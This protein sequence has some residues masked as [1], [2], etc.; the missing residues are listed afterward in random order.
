MLEL[1][2]QWLALDALD[3]SRLVVVSRGAVAARPGDPLAD[4]PAAAA[5]GLVRS[6]QS[7]HPGRLVLADLPYT[8]GDVD[9]QA[10]AGAVGVLAAAL[11]SAEPEL[12][13]R[14]GRGYGRRLVRPAAAPAPAAPPRDLAG[15][16]L[17]TGG[18]GTLAALV[19]R[20]LA[21]T[22]RA[23]HL[24]L[25]SRSGPLAPGAAALAAELAEAGTGT[26]TGV[27][28][29]A[30]DAAD[31]PALAAVLSRAGLTGV[32]HT[33][34]VLDDGVIDSL[35]ADRVH[36]VMR[37]K[38]DAAWN[39][40]LLT[41]GLDLDFFA[42]FSSAAATFGAAGQGN[43][44]AGNAFLDALAAHRRTAGLPAVSLAW[45]LWADASGLT[46]HLSDGDRERMTRGGVGAM[47]A[48]EALALLDQAL[49]LDEALLV[50]ARLD[51]AGLRAQVARSGTNASVPP[52]LR[53]L[54]GGSS[55]AAAG[56]GTAG[57]ALRTQLAGLSPAEAERTL[58]DLVRAHASAVLGHGPN[59]T[60]EPGR[61]F[62]DVGFDSLTA[63]ELRNRLAAATGLKLPVTLVFDHP[64]PE[65][66][67]AQLH[68]ELRS[69]PG[70]PQPAR[71]ALPAVAAAA[72]TSRSRSSASAAASPAAP[73]TPTASGNCCA[74]APT[75]SRASPPTAA[76]TPTPSTPP[77]ARARPRPR[78]SAD[79]ST[80]R[81]SSTPASS[82]SARAR[83]WR[84]TRSSG[85]CWRPPG[86]P[87]SA[88]ASTRP[89]CA[90]APP[91]SS[92][93]ATAVPG[94]ASA[95]RATGS[96][97]APAA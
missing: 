75:R 72:R 68:A 76:G 79:S 54:S 65:L 17:I 26:G 66:L 88:L 36:T 61:A 73:T 7:E 23:G 41:A 19:A 35:T 85:C 18:T 6:A 80:T 27:R 14:A 59:E 32:V 11:G 47:S 24:L 20:H 46:G 81:P 70:Q 62:R 87:W 71:T 28:I 95:R 58:T 37:P 84:P 57:E 16:V 83:R 39:L 69:R 64:V 93:A 94:T 13:V 44:A 96:P 86:R 5:W 8:D 53:S 15:T 56:S 60:M 40:H 33:A 55:R 4:L 82:A 92:R 97:A 34:G 50:P 77:G 10:G 91:G 90:A 3:D 1:V 30:C 38:A 21:A 45:G 74:A 89:P 48:E 78:G 25:A 31:R 29:V 51:V 42:L 67:A 12:A 2:Q 9:P 52:L 22:G 49:T 43:Y 63:V